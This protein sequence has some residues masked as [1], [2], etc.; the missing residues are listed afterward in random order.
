M[1]SSAIIAGDMPE[2]DDI[3]DDLKALNQII[4]TLNRTVDVRD[5]LDSAL[6][7]LLDVMGLE[8][9]WIFLREPDN[10]DLWGGRGYTL[11]AHMNLPP[12]IASD[13]ADAWEKGCD[14]QGYCD[15][16]KLTGAYNELYCTRLEEARGDRRGLVVHASAPLRSGNSILGILNVAATDWS[17][18]SPRALAFL[19]N[20]GNH[21]GVA[22][23]RARLYDLM[24]DR[25]IHEQRTLLEFSDQMLR[26]LDLQDLINH[27]VGEIPRLL[28]AD[29]CALLLSDPDTNAMRVYASYGWENGPDNNGQ[30]PSEVQAWLYYAMHASQLQV[31]TDISEGNVPPALSSWLHGQGFR[32]TATA[33]LVSESGPVGLVLLS[34]HSGWTLDKHDIHFLQLLTNQ[35][36]I[37]IENAR[38]LQAELV[39]QRMQAELAMGSRIQRSLLPRNLPEVEGWEFAVYYR[40][41]RQVGGDFYDFIELPRGKKHWG[42]VIADVVDKGVPAALVMTL[43]RTV[44]RSTAASGRSPA[45]ALLRANEI[46]RKDSGRYGMNE[47]QEEEIFVSAVYAALDTEND[48]LTYANAGHNRP[49]WL[50][51]AKDKIEELTGRGIVLGLLDEIDLE[52]CQIKIEAGESLLFYTDGISEAMDNQGNEFGVERIYASLQETLQSNAQELLAHLVQAVEDFT[53]DAEQS[54]DLTV[55]VVRRKKI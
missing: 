21:M 45:D 34:S 5:A 46:I 53:G 8:T 33:P 25:R 19:N 47:G 30:L 38:L 43:C 50:R 4:E 32:A 54:D 22:L 11:A 12:A 2:Q 44:F 7:S 49:L 17:S 26:R 40:S 3:I 39:Q 13:R 29:G 15:H 9:G 14:C 48:L 23:E 35:A 36:A 27:L 37:A 18:F 41:A 10:P 24:R 42:L 6:K 52:E 28:N 1:R 20:V 55:F 51:P 31:I 16:G